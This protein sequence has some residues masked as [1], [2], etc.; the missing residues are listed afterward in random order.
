MKILAVN[1]SPT[2][3]KG[4]T[5]ILLD[6]FLQGAAEAGAE[7]ERFNVVDKKIKY[8]DGCFNCWVRTP[9]ECIHKDDMPAILDQVAAA[10]AL[11]L[12]TP[13]Y[14]D[15]MTAQMKT[16]V[17][18]IIPLVEPEFEMVEG[19]YRH[20]SRISKI[21]GIFLMSVCGFWEADN[22]DGLVDHIKRICK[23]FQADYLGELLRP[24]S[25]ILAMDDLFPKEVAAI[26]EG[27]RQAGREFVTNGQISETTMEAAVAQPIPKEPALQGSNMF[28]AECRKQKKFIFHHRDSAV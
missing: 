15:G 27:I 24:N 8:C 7:V 28:W 4:M 1:G 18:R 2:T 10:D 12:A 22:F 5:H 13:L 19:H 14:V 26:H 6:L 23:N 11:I 9:G 17:D 3:K 25:Y 20:K 16:F 21:P